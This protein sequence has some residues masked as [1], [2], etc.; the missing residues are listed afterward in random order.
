MWTELTCEQHHLGLCSFFLLVSIFP[1]SL[2]LCQNRL[3]R[4]TVGESCLLSGWLLPHL[5]S[6]RAPRTGI[7]QLI[8]IRNTFF[9]S[10]VNTLAQCTSSSALLWLQLSSSVL[11]THWISM[12]RWSFIYSLSLTKLI[13]WNTYERS[14]P[15]T[16]VEPCLDWL[17]NV[18]RKEKTFVCSAK[19][20]VK[21]GTVW[22]AAKSN[23]SLW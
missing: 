13:N 2:S 11:S 20:S 19:S 1:L 9:F 15:A 23:P 17:L 22:G 21:V 18:L 10:I 3:E 16:D 14:W 5:I 4:Q 7:S 6:T 12:E 8:V